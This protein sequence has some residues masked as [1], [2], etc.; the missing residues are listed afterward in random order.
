MADT[1][2]QRAADT[3][4]RG[5]DGKIFRL[6]QERLTLLAAA[7]RILDIDAELLVLQVEKTRIDPRRPPVLV[8]LPAIVDGNDPRVR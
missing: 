1:P 2:D 6:Q 8:N 3:I 7:A 5:I 4:G